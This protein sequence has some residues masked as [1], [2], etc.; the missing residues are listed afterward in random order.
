M[1]KYLFVFVMFTL[2]YNVF[3]EFY[4]VKANALNVRSKPTKDSKVVRVLKK[5]DKVNVLKKSNNWA[6]VDENEWTYLPLLSTQFV[7][8]EKPKSSNN[9]SKISNYDIKEAVRNFSYPLTC[10]NW[11]IGKPK[12]AVGESNY[13]V[14]VYCDCEHPDVPDYV[15]KAHFYVLISK[16]TLKP[17][18]VIDV[19]E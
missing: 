7:S 6:K 1:K 8:K 5:G 13:A 15:L 9:I 3:A 2:A 19:N 12:D 16:T 18:R 4:Y 17:V 14:Q 10:S 11:S